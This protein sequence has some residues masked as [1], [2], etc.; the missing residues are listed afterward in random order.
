MEIKLNKDQYKA[1]TNAGI[2]SEILQLTLKQRDESDRMKEFFYVIGLDTRLNITFIEITGIGTLTACLV[3]PR[4]TFK[5][6]ILK[7]AA[8]IMIA[9]NHPSGE[10]DPSNDD[11]SITKKLVD[12][13]KILGIEVLDHI[14]FTE[15][16]YLSFKS[17]YLM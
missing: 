2:I 8:N 17:K 1:V 10:V 9:H 14:I 16:S 5:I 15:N 3:H 4:E 13:G 7:N 6:A 12:S 11:L